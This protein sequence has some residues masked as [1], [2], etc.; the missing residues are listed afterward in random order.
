MEPDALDLAEE[1]TW[2]ALD[3]ASE[4][5]DVAWEALDAR[6]RRRW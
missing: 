3:V 5:L 1:R 6:D 4:A 2:D